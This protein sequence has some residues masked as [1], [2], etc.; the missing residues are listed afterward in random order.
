MVLISGNADHARGRVYRYEVPRRLCT[1]FGV[2]ELYF[3]V[4]V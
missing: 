3:G 2:E 4:G 1:G